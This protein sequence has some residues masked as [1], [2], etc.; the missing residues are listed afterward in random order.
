MGFSFGCLPASP[1]NPTTQ[2]PTPPTKAKEHQGGVLHRRSS[3]NDLRSKKKANKY[4]YVVLS[5]STGVLLSRRFQVSSQVEKQQP[6]LWSTT[7]GFI[8]GGAGEAKAGGLSGEGRLCRGV[9]GPRGNFCKCF[10][11]GWEASLEGSPPWPGGTLGVLGGAP[12]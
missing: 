3:K 5:Q 7:L 2:R 10:R 1:F 9:S 11:V 4:Q 12:G 8:L 6:A